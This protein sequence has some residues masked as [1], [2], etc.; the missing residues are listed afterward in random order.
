MVKKRLFVWSAGIVCVLCVLAGGVTYAGLRFAAIGKGL[1]AVGLYVPLVD[2]VNGMQRW[3]VDR[4]TASCL[5]D[6]KSLDV[7]YRQP[8]TVHGPGACGVTDGV[9][10]EK[11]GAMQVD[12]APVMTCRMAT[13]LTH[14]VTDQMQPLAQRTL[15]SPVVRLR[16]VGTYNCRSIR[17]RPGHTGQALLSQHAFANALDVAGVDLANGQKVSVMRQWAGVTPQATFLHQVADA[18]CETFSVALSPDADRNHKGH[19]HWDMGPFH[20]CR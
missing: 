4:N 14:F 11:I 10:V 8:Q 17:P 7:T 16:H 20:A 19:F 18:A 3:Y 12:H 9:R 2:G 5:S 1:D 15:G 6:L 13:A